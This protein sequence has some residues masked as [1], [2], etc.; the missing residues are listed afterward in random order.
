MILEFPFR[1]DLKVAIRWE[2]GMTSWI[3]ICI[4]LF[5]IKKHVIVH[6]MNGK[7]WGSLTPPHLL[8]VTVITSTLKT[9]C[10]RI[11]TSLL[12]AEVSVSKHGPPR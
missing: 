6:I 8:L 12:E 4:V 7:G 1:R 9:N 10:L 3:R 2:V 11:L 5:K